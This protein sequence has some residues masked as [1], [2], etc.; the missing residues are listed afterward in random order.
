MTAGSR[1]TIPY[2]PG[3]LLGPAHGSW[4][5]QT[6]R[7]DLDDA[8]RQRRMVR[9][10]ADRPLA[11]G[12]VPHLVD[13]ALRA[14]TAGNTRGTAWVVLEGHAETQRYWLAATDAEWRSRSR[15]WGGLSRAPAIAVSLSSPD[16]YAVRYAAPDKRAAAGSGAAD[17]P[18]P[19]WVADAAFGAMTLLL[20]ATAE[21]IGACFLGNFRNEG[22]VLHALGVPGGW[23]LF[24]A[25]AL[26]HPDGAEHRS[27]SLDR[28]G[29]GR[30]SRLHRGRWGTV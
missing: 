16:A 21:G 8:V 19:Y 6:W 26:G 15:R 25:V 24:G 1:W 23:R 28:P 10:F 11:P 17:W 22:A 4:S 2:Q 9:S 27:A 18:V 20:G 14:P 7:M 30:G 12:L 13:A 5:S 3:Q 29:P